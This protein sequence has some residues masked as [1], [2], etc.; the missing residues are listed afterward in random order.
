MSK[1]LGRLD[2]VR[3]AK[4]SL[5]TQTATV[6]FVPGQPIDVGALAK[7]VDK[8]G[9]T[10]GKITIWATGRLKTD[11]RPTFTVSG[12]N[13]SFPVADSAGLADLRQG[14]GREISIVAEVAF[15]E[16]PPRL[17]FVEE[18]AEADMKGMRGMKGM[19]Q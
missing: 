5:K 7:A 12:T 11:E 16:H 18:P 15:E 17:I 14:A 2:A 3:D 13:Q 19:N 8:A 10:A 4:A 1:S 6:T 9:F